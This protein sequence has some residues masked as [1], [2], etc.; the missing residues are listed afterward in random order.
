MNASARAAGYPGEGELQAASAPWGG[1]LVDL[2]MVLIPASECIQFHVVGTLFAPDI[3]LLALL[4][5]VVASKAQLL[6]LRLPRTFLLWGAAWLFVQ[7]ATDLIRSTPLDD[8]LRGWAMIAFT[9]T[10][11]TVLYVLLYQNRRRIVLY[12]FGL[13]SGGV[14][15]YFLSPGMFAAG[16]PWKFGYGYGITLVIVLLATRAAG[17]SRTLTAAVLIALAAV[18][19][20]YNGFRSLAGVCFLASAYLLVQRLARVRRERGMRVS[21]AGALAAYAILALSSAGVLRLYE[22]CAGNGMLGY[23]AWNKYEVQSSGRYGILIGG[24]ADFLTGT[25]AVLDSPIVGHGS[26]AKDWR[27]A[28]RT[29]S[30]M[31][32]LGYGVQDTPESW[33]IPSHSYLLSAW[34][35]AGVVGAIFWL[36]VLSLSLRVLARLYATAEPL[37]P[38]VAFLAIGFIW[39]VLFSPFGAT[40]RLSVS[41]VVVTLMW[42]LETHPRFDGPAA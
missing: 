24:R 38:L 28:S 39:D 10:N 12:A 3:L 29:E 34:I 6:R 5:F 40:A 41:F 30:V 17:R 25:E 36:W 37:A 7:M 11:F 32:D 1:R 2:L 8:Y 15:S 26:W 42:F 19:N 21:F 13:A 23:E 16:D 35:D 20:L 22:Y 27:Y 4:P 18:L 31:A 33:T 14:L 9:L